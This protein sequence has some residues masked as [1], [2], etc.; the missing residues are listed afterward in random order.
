MAMG[1]RRLVTVV[2]PAVAGLALV[3]ASAGPAAAKGPTEL[4]ITPP[5]GGPPVELEMGSLS[6]DLGLW[7]ALGDPEGPRFSAEP[8]VAPV[9]EPYIVR[10][11]MYHPTE[12]PI[13]ITQQL[14]L[15]SSGGGLIYTEPG[16]E[17]GPYAPDGIGSGGW[18]QAP[19]DLGARLAAAGFDPTSPPAVAAPAAKTTADEARASDDGA[20]NGW[21]APV[22][23]AA[24]AAVGA[25]ALAAAATAVRRG[26][27]AR[28]AA[29]AA[30]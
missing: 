1:G 18:L 13:V 10:W 3:V 25:T 16:Q 6:E 5:G 9:G 28:D 20:T 22:G 27:R 14:W 11:T 17:M 26:R 24:A 12:T 29:P 23:L 15:D 30:G 7:S 2:G 4:T 21:W 19:A 8:P